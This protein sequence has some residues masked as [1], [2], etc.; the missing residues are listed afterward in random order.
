MAS[1]FAGNTIMN[2]EIPISNL[3]GYGDNGLAAID[4]FSK[5]PSEK[6]VLINAFNVFKILCIKKPY[7]N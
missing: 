4:Y 7:I 3:K 6:E 1:A 5:H 2:I